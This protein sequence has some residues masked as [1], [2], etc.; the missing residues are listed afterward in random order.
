MLDKLTPE[1][2]HV[3]LLVLVPLLGYAAATVVPAIDNAALAG[4][5]GVVLAALLAYFTPLTRQYGVGSGHGQDGVS[6]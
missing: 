1:L 4:A 5:A 6:E 3:L 2:R